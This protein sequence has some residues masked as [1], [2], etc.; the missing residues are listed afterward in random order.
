MEWR[1]E[2]SA[3]GRALVRALFRAAAEAQ[4]E[5]P[6]TRLEVSDGGVVE[7]DLASGWPAP[8]SHER[9]V[10]YGKRTQVRRSIFEGL[11]PSE[12]RR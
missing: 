9:T 2:E 6:D 10:R 12:G 7:F 4:G 11:S 8:V 5:A 1:N 3:E